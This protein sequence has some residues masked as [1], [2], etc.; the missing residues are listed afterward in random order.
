[1][2]TTAPACELVHA[3]EARAPLLSPFSKVWGDTTARPNAPAAPSPPSRAAPSVA[4]NLDGRCSPRRRCR[5]RSHR[6]T[7]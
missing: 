2:S 5:P 3:S 4:T 6:R 7:E 1:M